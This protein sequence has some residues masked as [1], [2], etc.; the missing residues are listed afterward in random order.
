[1][2]LLE[3]TASQI[4]LTFNLLFGGYRHSGMGDVEF[5][6]RMLYE[7]RRANGIPYLIED[8][9]E[10]EVVAVIEAVD[11]VNQRWPGSF[12]P[13]HPPRPR[14]ADRN[15]V[16]WI[17]DFRAFWPGRLDNPLHPSSGDITRVALGGAWETDGK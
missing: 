3:E 11:R 17:M 13:V 9:T 1:M 8:R 10:E 2:N 6:A 4:V 12:I 7:R 5:K 14:P 16:I 15:Q